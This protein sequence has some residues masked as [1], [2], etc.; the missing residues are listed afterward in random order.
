MRPKSSLR[1]KEVKKQSKVA[2]LDAVH[3]QNECP[4]I[5][6]ISKKDE[7]V[8]M[9]F[10]YKD[11]TELL[12]KTIFRSSAGIIMD[13]IIN[14]LM[15]SFMGDIFGYHQIKMAPKDE[16]KFMFATPWGTSYYKIKPFGLKIAWAV[17]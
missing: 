3:I 14:H 17:Y 2:F 11:L 6:L 5:V 8:R 13:N 10:D 9:S 7:R 4:N 12:Q 15:F 16:E 1:S